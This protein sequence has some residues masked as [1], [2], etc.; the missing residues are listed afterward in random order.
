MRRLYSFYEAL[1][2]GAYPVNWPI[3]KSHHK[4]AML[5]YDQMGLS[6]SIIFDNSKL[7]SVLLP[8]LSSVPYQLPR[9]KDGTPLIIAMLK[10]F[11]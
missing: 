5:F 11:L 3:S 2:L 8:L 4:D 6:P 9:L 1:S 7:D 10:K